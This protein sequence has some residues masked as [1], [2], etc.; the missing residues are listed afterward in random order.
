MFTHIFVSLLCL[1]T[2]IILSKTLF[3]YLK[4]IRMN[5]RLTNRGIE[6]EALLLNIEQTGLYINNQPQVKMQLQVH[7]LTGRNFVS[8]TCEVFSFPDLCSI[9]IGSKLK[10]RYNPENCKEV[11]VV[12]K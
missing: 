7:P 9:Q 1:A 11:M 2:C 5:R 3:P 10:V 8:E 6:A 12:R 4:I